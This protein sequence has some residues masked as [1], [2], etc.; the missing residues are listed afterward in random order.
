[1]CENLMTNY[2]ETDL[3]RD[4]H[5]EKATI[6]LYEFND[7]EAAKQTFDEFTRTYPDDPLVEH[8]KIILDNYTPL[9]AKLPKQM[10]QEALPMNNIPIPEKY[11]LAQNYPN[12]FNPET[13]IR[14][15]LPENCQVSLLVHN[16]LGQQIRTLVDKQQPAGFHSIRWDGKDDQGQ[17]VTSGVYLYLM[18][19]KQF[20]RVEKMLLLR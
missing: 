9:L 14:Y 16:L 8:I 10:A 20:R 2:K 5:F 19:A 18:I 1:L 13:E 7:I 17:A 12:P 3:A 11:A 6:Q 4:A 15:Q